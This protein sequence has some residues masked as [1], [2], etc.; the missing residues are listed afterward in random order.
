[1]VE[2]TFFYMALFL[3]CIGL[4][5]QFWRFN[6]DH[7]VLN[8]RKIPGA[9]LDIK[10]F[11]TSIFYQ[12]RLFKA[13]KVRWGIHFALVIGFL[14][15][16]IVHGLW[17]VTA[18]FLFDDYQ[19]TLNPF[20]PLRNLTGFF[21]L[22]GC[23]AFFYR[24]RRNFRVN[25]DKKV[26]TKGLAVVGLILCII[27]S[28]FLLEATKII[29]EPV[30][31]E[32]VEE[33]SDLDGEDELVDLKAYW[34]EHYSVV[35][36]ETLE[37]SDEQLE[38]G[39]LLNEDYCLYCHSPI[40][41]AALSNLIANIIS[42]MGNWLN[43]IRA[44]RIIYWFHYLSC[45]VL[46]V[47]LPFSRISHLLFIPIASGRK[48]L[49][50]KDVTDHG[51]AIHP[52]VLEACTN[53]G[54]CTEVCSVYP[55]FQVQG[56]PDILPH[57][58]IESVKMLIKDPGNVNPDLLQKGNNACTLC[59]KCTDICP[60]GIDLQSLWMVLD[61]NLGR[62]GIESSL[63]Y[64]NKT[65]LKDWHQKESV[66]VSTIPDG[67]A[68]ISSNLADNVQSFESCIQCTV[69]TNVCPVVGYDTDLN[70][71]SPHQIMNLLRLGKK[72][73]ATGT[74]MVWSCLTCY[75][76]QEN[77]PQHIPV[78]DIILEMRNLGAVKAAGLQKVEPYQKV[79][80]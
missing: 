21:V 17:T 76:C 41:S 23:I 39:A 31:M 67:M 1:M 2:T 70:D 72:H 5:Y 37:M 62:N 42:F 56:N 12:E 43:Q 49:T 36:Q 54:Y 68:P 26:K 11:I 29:S 65:T 14:Y 58:K 8:S 47:I 61:E 22:V 71:M 40:K 20:Q 74:R 66:A 35:F 34:K 38:N 52:M 45:L 59:H 60:S 24:R 44:D 13:D 46:L 77:C 57:S 15:L 9:K 30:F 16:L 51:A 10:H 25:S 73:L 55:N 53:C 48:S 50:L 69:C 7:P 63:E 33:F 32:M 79:D 75:S 80:G 4:G 64:I 18:D 3:C 19:P 78:T 28:G 27:G 6:A